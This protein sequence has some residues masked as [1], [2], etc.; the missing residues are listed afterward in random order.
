[1]DKKTN[2]EVI[3]W[4]FFLLTINRINNYMVLKILSKLFKDGKKTV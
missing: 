3:Y 1:M 2:N 4:F